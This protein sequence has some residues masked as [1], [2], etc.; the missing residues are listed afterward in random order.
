MHVY[1]I[2]LLIALFMVW[3]VRQLGLLDN[4]L[5]LTSQTQIISG[6]LCA[7]LLLECVIQSSLFVLILFLL[8]VPLLKPAKVKL[9]EFLFLLKVLY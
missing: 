7:V 3:N 2:S 9:S 4:M 8:C 5:M 6:M 1:L